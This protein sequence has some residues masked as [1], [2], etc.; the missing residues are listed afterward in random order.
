LQDVDT[1]GGFGVELGQ[2]R[3]RGRLGHARVGLG[4]VSGGVGGISASPSVRAVK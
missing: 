4:A 2:Q 1:G 3:A